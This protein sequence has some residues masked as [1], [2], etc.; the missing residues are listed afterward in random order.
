[1]EKDAS[2]EP[3]SYQERVIIRI[4]KCNLMHFG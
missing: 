3:D 4:N 2:F 1:M